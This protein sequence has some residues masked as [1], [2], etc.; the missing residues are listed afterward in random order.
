M[1][2]EKGVCEMLVV[3]VR[4][5]TCGEEFEVQIL[6]DDDPKER[7]LQGPPV[8]CRNPRCRSSEIARVRDLRKAPRP[9]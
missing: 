8:R 9:R 7:H 6:D 4:C 2:D 3:L 5:K 1:T